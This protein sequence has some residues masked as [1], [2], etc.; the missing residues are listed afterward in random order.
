MDGIDSITLS[1]VAFACIFSSAVLG[2][3][4]TS[5]AP[6][7]F[8]TPHTREIFKSARDVIVGVAA[9]TLGLLIATAKSSYDEKNSQLKIEA[10]KAI[11]LD[12]TLYYLGPEALEARKLVRQ[13]VEKGIHKIENAAAHGVNGEFQ[14]QGNM[15]E[16]LYLKILQLKPNDRVKP[17][18]QGSALSLTKEIM[19]SRWMI[20]Q[21]L[22]STVQ[23]PLLAILVFWLSCVFLNLG[24]M[25][26]HNIA[27]ISSLFLAALSMTGAIYLTL[28]FDRP[29]QGL[30]RISAAPLKLALEQLMPL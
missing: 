23:L 20:H 3:C 10:S 6:E 14:R 22:N 24:F 27:A 21:S 9:L 12:R 11:L 7:T 25:A 19:H 4:L 18:L 15:Q 2:I 5:L 26:G 1:L 17:E 8:A 16:E 28:A 29:Y 30:I 13:I